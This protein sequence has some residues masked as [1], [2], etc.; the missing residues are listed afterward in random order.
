MVP[1]CIL[2]RTMELPVRDVRPASI[3]PPLVTPCL[4]WA[5]ASDSGLQC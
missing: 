3:P 5:Y 2:E 1:R 4:P